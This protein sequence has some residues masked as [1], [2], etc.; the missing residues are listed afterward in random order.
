MQYRLKYGILFQHQKQKKLQCTDEC[1]IYLGLQSFLYVADFIE[2]GSFSVV[3]SMTRH[4][5]DTNLQGKPID[6]REEFVQLFMSIMLG[7]RRI[8][9]SDDSLEDDAV[10]CY[11]ALIHARDEGMSGCV[12]GMCCADQL[13]EW[14]EYVRSVLLLIIRNACRCFKKV[15]LVVI[16]AFLNVRNNVFVNRNDAI[17]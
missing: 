4:T 9:M 6:G 12:R 5:Q 16:K 14:S 17:G 11:S 10:C 3:F 7:D 2:N 8:G 1:L 13:H 15:F